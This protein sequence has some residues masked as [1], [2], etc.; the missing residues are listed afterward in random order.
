LALLPVASLHTDY[1][2]IPNLCEIRHILLIRVLLPVFDSSTK[3]PESVLM[4]QSVFL[5]N[6]DECIEVEN[7]ET[8][9]GTF[10]GKHCLAN[11]QLN[12]TAIQTPSMQNVPDIEAFRRRVRNAGDIDLSVSGL[13]KLI[14]R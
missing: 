13:P 4:G 9:V 3:F 1:F 7:V 8:A 14:Q 10:S 2:T 5:G 6:F 12:L 11:F